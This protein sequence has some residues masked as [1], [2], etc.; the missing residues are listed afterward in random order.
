MPLIGQS[1]YERD[2]ANGKLKG[3]HDLG[4]A[5]KSIAATGGIT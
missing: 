1:Q 4:T 3:G 2:P 5:G